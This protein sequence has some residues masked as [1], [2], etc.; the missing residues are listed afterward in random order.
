MGCFVKGNEPSGYINS[1]EYIERLSN[2]YL[3]KMNSAPLQPVCF[4]K[5]CSMCNIIYHSSLSDPKV[6]QGA[7]ISDF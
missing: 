4:S 3:L 6:T 2:C 1:K 5:L 7:E